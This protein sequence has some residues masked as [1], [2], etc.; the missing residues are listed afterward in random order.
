MIGFKY[1]ILSLGLFLPA[2]SLPVLE[3][4]RQDGETIPNQY[5]ITLKKNLVATEVESH[6]S[7]VSDVHSRSLSRRDTV[8]LE[9]TFS[10]G[11]FNAYAGEFDD[12]TIAQISKNK[13][14]AAF[15]PNKIALVTTLVSQTNAPWG[16]ASLSNPSLPSGNIMGQTYVYDEKAG[17]DTW[18]YVLDTGIFIE[19]TEFEGRAVKGYNAWPEDTFDDRFG[20]GSHVAGIIGSKTYG[21]VK[22]ANVVDVKV[23]RG[24]YSTV[25]HVLDGL[26]WAVKNITNTPGRASKSVVNLSLAFPT[27]DALNAGIEAAYAAGVL[28][29]VGAAN[30][31]KDASTKSPA[32]APSAI[33]VGA[34]AWNKTRASWSNY[35]LLVD[36]FAPGVD[37]PSLWN[38]QGIES[39]NSG[40]SMASPHVAG[41]VLYLKALENLATPAATTVRVKE[42]ALKGVVASPGTG[43]PNLLTYNGIGAG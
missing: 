7:W 33:T 38:G 35:G 17:A 20:H 41:L 31:G 43:S 4:T 21:V 42:L 11:D 25:A 12:E 29:V 13:N 27:S 34:V 26:D 3:E 37:I 5:I 23:V 22:K 9:R 30:D 36:I 19:N 6:L 10:I 24:G 40:T 32:S 39:V 18:A 8:G 16:I 1:I 28:S 15:E 2:F 14:V